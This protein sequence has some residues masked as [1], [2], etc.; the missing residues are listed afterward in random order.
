MGYTPITEEQAQK[1]IA[2]LQPWLPGEYLFEVRD[3]I[4]AG[5]TKP[6]FSGQTHPMALL[7]L[8]LV[9]DNGNEKLLKVYLPM[10]GVMAFKYRHAAVACGL[11]AAY[12]A[13]SLAPYMFKQKRGSAKLT[14]EDKQ[15]KKDTNG[16][17]IPGQFWPAKNVIDDFITENVKQADAKEVTA[18]S[19]AEV[20]FS[21]EIPF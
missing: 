9:N 16:I 11:Q 20:E 19:S 10:G 21:D 17:I 1:D 18:V 2:S 15:P 12:E 6:N 13:G 3:A 8:C 4:D 7:T 5:Y 14:I